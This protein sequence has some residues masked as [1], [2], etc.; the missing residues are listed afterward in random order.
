MELDVDGPRSREE[1]GEAGGGPGRGRKRVRLPNV[2]HLLP[3][4]ACAALHCV[5]MEPVARR[6]RGW[7]P[8]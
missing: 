6:V 5:H 7:N 1:G 2:L 8:V 4:A 3:R